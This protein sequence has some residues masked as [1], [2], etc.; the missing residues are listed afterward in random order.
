MLALLGAMRQETAG[1][2]RYLALGDGFFQHGCRI[3]RGKYESM[4]VVLVQTGVGKRRAERAT[5]LVLERY[6]ITTMV[7]LGF[8]GALTEE[9]KVGDV[10]L[11]STIHEE[12]GGE[13]PCHSSADLVSL[14]A[15]TVANTEMRLLQGDSV[16]V[17]R[18][19][20][21]TAAKQALG[22]A[23]SAKVVDMESYWIG[24]IASSKQ[25][26][27]LAVRS[28]SDSMADSLFPLDRFLDSNG[29]WQWKRAV[30][31]F[32]FR[33]HQLVKLGGLYR[34]ARK[35]RNSLSCLV[36]SLIPKL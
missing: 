10:I 28:I 17:A 12:G 26:P 35:A 6:P 22:K 1:L 36:A 15:Q 33:P 31:Y 8:G 34:N 7:S 9:A 14:A 23:F 25:V 3:Y 20:A 19:V 11:C 32:L 16:T 5:E 24:R 2:R 27:F 4:E 29:I 13:S 21:E 30:R 18:P